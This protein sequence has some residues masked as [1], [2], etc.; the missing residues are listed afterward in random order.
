MD[1]AAARIVN[2]FVGRYEAAWN[3]HGAD[4][5]AKLYTADSVL[6]GFTTAIGRPEILKL[7]EIIIGQGWTRIKIKVVNV[8]RVGDVI[9]FVN[10]Y[11]ATGSSGENTGKTISATASHV[12]VH[13]EGAWLSALHTAR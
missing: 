12:L 7:L 3:E 5:V 2:E 10:E 11:T 9:L 13:A 6:V 4:A 8:R 1:D